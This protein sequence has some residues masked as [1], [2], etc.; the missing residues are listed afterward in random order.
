MA[1]QMEATRIFDAPVETVWEVWKDPELVK[2]W[3]GTKFFTSNL[4]KIDFKE[5][6]KT[7]VSTKEPKETGG[8]EYFTVWEYVKIIH[9]KKIEFIQNPADEAGN[10]TDPVKL[11]MPSDFPSNVKTVVTFQ[12]VGKNKTEMTIAK[13]AEFGSM[14]NFAQI[15]LDQSMEKME[16]MFY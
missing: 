11:G 13:Y 9:L 8:H 7:L 6:G 2:R 12:E 4:A 15:A 3:W 1:K 14:S 5:G 16:A 10:K